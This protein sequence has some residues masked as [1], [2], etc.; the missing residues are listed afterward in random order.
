MKHSLLAI[1]LIVAANDSSRAEVIASIDF[2]GNLADGVYGFVYEQHASSVVPTPAPVLAVPGG[3]FGNVLTATAD[4]SGVDAGSTFWGFGV[5]VVKNGVSLPT[6]N[7]SQLTVEVASWASGFNDS[8]GHGVF[9]VEFAYLNTTAVSRYRFDRSSNG[10]FGLNGT[11]TVYT[12]T[13]DKA[14]IPTFAPFIPLTSSNFQ[15]VEK[16]TFQVEGIGQDDDGGDF[17]ADAD[18][19]IFAD[20]FLMTASVPE[21]GT[22]GILG[23]L[24]FCVAFRRSWAKRQMVSKGL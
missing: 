19:T 14:F 8:V 3:G 17:G 24:L 7:L 12:N 11:R 21:P 16:V 9:D 22:T 15:D 2:D 6:A 4:L 1:L 10:T 13:L 18:N 5:G 23:G 20:N